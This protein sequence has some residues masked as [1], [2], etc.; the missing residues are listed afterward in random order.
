MENNHKL[1]LYVAYYL[2]RFKNAG[3]TNLGC[4]T[5][6]N[7]FDDISDQL[8]VNKHSVK[9]GGMNSTP[10]LSIVPAGIKDR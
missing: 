2:S 3:L 8:K 7:A 9:T 10:Y 4:A 5:W 1:A 6:N